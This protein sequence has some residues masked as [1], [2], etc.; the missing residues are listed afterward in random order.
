MSLK[1]NDFTAQTELAN[2]EKVNS[3]LFE[4]L[5]QEQDNGETVIDLMDLFLSLIHI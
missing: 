1:K 4:P 5:L 2:A 3:N